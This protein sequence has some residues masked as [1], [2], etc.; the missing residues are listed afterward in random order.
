MLLVPTPVYLLASY[1][2]QN[3]IYFKV[4]LDKIVC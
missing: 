3:E 1:L 2:L 4:A